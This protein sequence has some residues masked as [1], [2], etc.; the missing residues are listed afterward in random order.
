MNEN[1]LI[2]IMI[3]LTGYQFP[4]ADGDIQHVC[5][6]SPPNWYAFMGLMETYEIKY[7]QRCREYEQLYEEA[8]KALQ[9]LKERKDVSI[10]EWAKHFA[11]D[12]GNFTD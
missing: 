6:I 2:E 3:S 11:G 7:I 9:R 12:L 10:E 1:Q 5:E 4:K 8:E